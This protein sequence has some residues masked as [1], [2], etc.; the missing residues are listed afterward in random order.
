MMRTCVI[1]LGLLCS[2]VVQAQAAEP[3]SVDFNR[4]VRPILSETCFRCHGP[5]SAAREADLRLDNADDAFADR[6]DFFAIVPGEPEKSEAYR[7]LV[8]DDESLKMPPPDSKLALTPEQVETLRLWIAQGAKYEKHWSFITPTRPALPTVQQTNWPRNAIDYFVLAQLEE[9]GIAPAPRAARETLIRRLSLDLTGLPP[10]L[11]ELDAYLADESP[12]AYEKV[13]D[14]LLA[15]PAYGERMAKL[16]LD[17]ARYADTNGYQN[18]AERFMW[19][20]RDWVINAYNA[21]MPF[22]QFTIEQLAGD[23]LPNATLEQRIAT[24]FNRNHTTS[25]EGGIIP[26]EYRVDY[27]ANRLETTSTVWLGLT[28]GCARCHTHKY[29]PITQTEYYQLF[30]FFNNIPEKGKDGDKGNSVPFIKAP[31]PQQLAEQDRLKTAIADTEK[32]IAELV[33]GSA[34]QR[35][36]W[37]TATRQ[38]W[39]TKTAKPAEAPV[40]GMT[41]FAFDGPDSR[42]KGDVSLVPAHVT[43]G[44][45]LAADAPVTLG[46]VGAFDTATPFTISLWLRPSETGHGTLI[47]RRDDKRGYE[48]GLND[49][50]AV[51]V[52]LFHDG[53][54]NA[55]DVSASGELPVGRWSH[56]AVTYDGSGKAGGVQVYRDGHAEKLDIHQDTLNGTIAATAPLV[57]GT[58]KTDGPRFRGVVD[59][60]RIFAT[61]Q[62]AEQIQEHSVGRGADW[63]VAPIESVNSNGGAMFEIRDDGSVF[64]TGASPPQDDYLVEILTKRTDLSAIRLEVLK[65]EQLPKHGPGRREDGVFHL[66]EVEAEAVSVVDPHNTQ[67][68]HFT[69]AYANESRDGFDVGNLIDGNVEGKNSW[70]VE[71]DS[72]RAARNAILVAAEPFGFDG[73]T[74]LK[75]KLRHQSDIPSATLGRFRFSLNAQPTAVSGVVEQIAVD[76]ATPS[77]QRTESQQQRLERH[78]H[79]RT[80]RWGQAGT[81]TVGGITAGANRGRSGDSDDNGDAGDG[82]TTDRT[83]VDSGPV[84]PT[85]GRSQSGRSGESESIS[86]R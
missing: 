10:T 69:A 20:W 11:E 49:K 57:L 59:D 30:A 44:L 36:A 35:L 14:R 83:C 45:L 12:E 85:W 38:R 58:A 62:T 74:I 52:R 72:K 70:S 26:E 43:P 1:T 13:V 33:N 81:R 73:G 60:L 8:A 3:R 4:D 7:R 24:G 67:T 55:I 84:R 15:S 71:A 27:V 47:A 29:D 75:I 86:D 22:D 6:G 42:V 51:T 80:G 28:M 64:V 9:R 65:D 18:D 53:T 48:I 19:R 54:E 17:G 63:V 50:R 23:L 82:S 56:L 40:D 78:Y 79:P 66:S 41:R 31:T 37:E 61:N 5:D 76:L 16:W 77:E 32:T 68:I 25:D 46:D 2:F 21:N 39:S 34:K